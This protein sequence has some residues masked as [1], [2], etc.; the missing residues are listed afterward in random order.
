[1][2]TTKVISLA[3]GAFSPTWG[4]GC[5]PE[6]RRVGITWAPGSTS[7]TLD[8]TDEQLLELAREPRLV[9]SDP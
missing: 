9:V 3:V 8:L 2:S 7:Q 5:V 4:E 1:M 6:F